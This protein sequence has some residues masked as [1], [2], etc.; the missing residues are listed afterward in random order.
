MRKRLFTIALFLIG[1][2]VFLPE[3]VLALDEVTFSATGYVNLTGVGA[4]GTALSIDSGSQATQMVVGTS[5]IGLTIG[6]GDTMTFRSAT[7]NIM[8]TTSDTYQ[9]VCGSNESYI[10]IT[11]N[12]T[13]TLTTGLCPSSVVSS[14]GGGGAPAPAAAPAEETTTPAPTETILGEGIVT[15][16]AGG[17]VSATSSDGGGASVVLP[18]NA[19][20]ADTTI[21]VVPTV[22]SDSALTSAVAAV[23]SGSGLIGGYAYNYSAADSSGAVVTSFESNVTVTMTYT[24]SQISGYDESSLVINYWDAVAWQW[25][26]LSTVVNTATNTL[27]AT[28]DHFTYFAI[29]GQESAA[30]DISTMTIA[31]LEAKIVELQALIASAMA[32]L[33]ALLGASPITGIPSTFSFTANMSQ[34]QASE[35][36]KYLQI[37]LNSSSDTKVATTGVG[38]LGYETNY[39]GSL[40]KAAVIKFQEKYHS[41]VLAPWGF[42]SG[43]GFVGSTTREKLNSLLGK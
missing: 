6:T 31:E 9:T 32:Q 41:Q 38:S 17:T 40:T 16:A 1:L 39:F 30:E 4:N 19:V 2:A 11:G 8:T 28:T 29:I 24:D 18:A 7:K 22:S 27:T 35:S 12:T 3:A 14:G 25:T 10:T 5:T 33:A 23:P 15:A 34:G 21:S 36:V 26:A 37:V 13:L 20:S 43:T 42:T